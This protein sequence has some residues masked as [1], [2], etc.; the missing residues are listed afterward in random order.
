MTTNQPSIYTA[1]PW[2]QIV[3][4]QGRFDPPG[5]ILAY[6]VPPEV[7]QRWAER[8]TPHIR[9][10]L[11]VL[12][13]CGP[14]PTDISRAHTVRRL[15]AQ[16]A[17][18]DAYLFT[19]FACGLFHGERGED[20]LARLRSRADE[21]FRAAMA[22]CLACWFFAG[23]MQLPL[24][25][26]AEGRSERNLDMRVLVDDQE[27]GVEVKAPFRERPEGAWSGGESDKIAQAMQSANRQ[28]RDD[29]PNILVLV[30]EL[31]VPLHRH[32]DQ[33][34]R[35]AY[36]SSRLFVPINLET[37][38]TEN[39]FE[40]FV[41]DGQFLNRERPGGKPLKPDGL[42][43]YRR[44]SVVVSIEEVVRDRHPMPDLR[45]F[46]CGE[47]LV[48]QLWPYWDEARTLHFSE[49][50]RA[51]VEHE[52]LIL[53]NPHA[54]HPLRSEVWTPFPQFVPDGSTMKWT[55][56]LRVSV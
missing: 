54:Y 30:P 23:H 36:G 42:P 19:A 16:K 11:A 28:F 14:Y 18:W 25:P 40:D 32:R 35:A 13:A 34:L 53:H 2:N 47:Q 7:R 41:A 49:D 46:L 17:A 44:I 3:P 10:R 4:G 29:Q 50:N 33:L 5:D 38:E 43:G 56:G 52:V 22:E 26:V 8:P 48:H 31:R 1:A 45:L 37:G 21:D 24:D 27:V 51:W 55:D 39:P 6:V 9:W 15:R 12:S 20:V